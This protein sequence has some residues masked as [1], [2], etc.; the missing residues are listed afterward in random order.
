MDSAPSSTSVAIVGLGAIGTRLVVE[1]ACAGTSDVFA[2]ARRKFAALELVGVETPLECTPRIEVDSARASRVDWVLLCTKAQQV[3]SARNWLRALRRDDTPVA[4][5]Q[6]GVEHR[7]RLAGIVRGELVVPVVVEAPT[8]RARDGSVRARGPARLRVSR[9]ALGQRFAEL[10]RGSNV[11]VE[12]VDDVRALAWAKLVH[13][14]AG[15][16]RALEARS[17]LAAVLGRRVLAERLAAEA[18]EVATALGVVLPAGAGASATAAALALEPDRRTSLES[19]LALGRPTEIDARNGAVAR[20]AAQLGVDVR[21][22][23]L[24]LQQLR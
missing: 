8:E 17:T 24:A 13:N 12:Q 18:V 15:A 20:L 7:E 9:D 11:L 4:V 3:E 1:L 23:A 6:N 2:C 22:N 5:L 21:W 14:C 16:A 10:F 19:D